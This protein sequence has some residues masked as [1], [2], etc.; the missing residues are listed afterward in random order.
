CSF[1]DA[2]GAARSTS[3]QRSSSPRPDNVRQRRLERARA[4]ILEEAEE[5]DE[6]AEDDESV[7]EDVS[8][9]EDGP[10][11]RDIDGAYRRDELYNSQKNGDITDYLAI[12]YGGKMV[13]LKEMPD[14]LRIIKPSDDLQKSQ[15]VRIKSVLLKLLPRIDYSKR[16]F[17]P[18][19]TPVKGKK[20]KTKRPMAKPFNESAIKDIGGEVTHENNFLVFEGNR[21]S[22]NGFLYKKFPLKGV[23]KSGVRPSLAEVE[24]LEAWTSALAEAEAAAAATAPQ[25]LA[26]GDRVAVCAG[27]LIGLSGQVARVDGVGSGAVVTSGFVVRVEENRVVLLSDS[28]CQEIEVL[29]QDLQKSCGTVT[30]VAPVSSFQWG[31]VVQLDSQTVGIVVSVKGRNVYI[32]SM[33]DKIIEVKPQSLQKKGGRGFVFAPDVN[34]N[35]VQRHD[36]VKVIDGRH[37]GRN[38]EVKFLFGEYA[39]LYSNLYEDNRGYFVC[40]TRQVLLAGAQEELVPNGRVTNAASPRAV[41]RGGSGGG[42]GW[43][44]GP[45][46]DTTLIGKTVQI[47]RGNFKGS[48][49][50]VRDATQRVVWVE[51]HAG[52]QSIAVDRARVVCV[53]VRPA[54]PSAATP[55]TAAST[56][57]ATPFSTP[58]TTPCATPCVTPCATPLY[59]EGSTTPYTTPP[60]TPRLGGWTPSHCGSCTPSDSIISTSTAKTCEFEN[61]SRSCNDL[62]TQY[63][64]CGFF[65]A[66]GKRQLLNMNCIDVYNRRFFD[67]CYPPGGSRAA[68]RGAGPVRTAGEPGAPLRMD[69]RRANIARFRPGFA[70]SP[71]S[72]ALLRP[73]VNSATALLL[74]WVLLSC[75]AM[76][77]KHNK[78]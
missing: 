60:D 65:F 13:P 41:R 69:L 38:G 45:S 49:G 42:G 19:G 35:A 47:V 16:R 10:S 77:L 53:D 25:R 31:D 62:N 33:Y 28:A 20:K 8:S 23:I 37:T 27:E 70:L 61:Y 12:K 55:F 67:I 57:C 24:Q 63:T 56:P 75:Y 44:G 72:T 9:E 71:A 73:W 4:F 51:L 6:S 29:P 7:G 59:R 21:Y 32:L 15:W 58:G 17:S 68:R 78:L 76:E 46:R 52:C 14:A 30:A 43:P 18:R 50:V 54:T 3:K 39:F 36:Y 48:V 66:T 22:K 2:S 40:K 1:Q 5:D 64:R 74:T 34:S 26:P 11:A